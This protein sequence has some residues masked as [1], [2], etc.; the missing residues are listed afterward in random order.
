MTEQEIIFE[1][2]LTTL[3]EWGKSFDFQ[4]FEDQYNEYD[5]DTMVLIHQDV[6]QRILDNSK[7][8]MKILYPTGLPNRL[9]NRLNK[10]EL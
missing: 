2:A 3:G 7:K 8:I 9:L 6:G 4:A 1:R 10:F 5:T